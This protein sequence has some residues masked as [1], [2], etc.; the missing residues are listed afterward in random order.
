MVIT[1]VGQYVGQADPQVTAPLGDDWLVQADGYRHRHA[2]R[3]IV[4]DGQ[5]RALLVRG[6]DA[7][8]VERSWWFT[9]GGGIEAGESAR[10]AA[11]RELREEAGIEV[12]PQALRGPVVTRRGKF[13]FF[14]ETVI[15]HE[16]F[17][18]LTVSS[19]DMPVHAGGWTATE[20]DL[21]DE[22]AWM[23]AQELR[24][25][26]C[27]FFPIALPDILDTLVEQG[28]DGQVTHLG[29]EDDDADAGALNDAP[30]DVTG[31]A[32]D[33]APGGA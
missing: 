14:A 2:A 22:L 18:L 24:S 20:Q 6:H 25:Q 31:G 21:L 32:V 15:Q 7:D 33:D 8:Q 28:W 13:H 12:D 29:D 17:Y 5:G 3:V 26:P 11:A 30:G 10:Q 19:H 16:V 4:L 27:E 1:H 23:T 9:V